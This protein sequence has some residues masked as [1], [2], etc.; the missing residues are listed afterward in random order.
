MTGAK[1]RLKFQ[2]KILPTKF[3]QMAQGPSRPSSGPKGP[4]TGIGNM[5]PAGWPVHGPAHGPQP[6]PYSPPTVQPVIRRGGS[7]M[8]TRAELDREEGE[9]RRLAGRPDR[10]G[11]QPDNTAEREKSRA[12]ARRALFPTPPRLRD[13]VARAVF[14]ILTNYDLYSISEQKRA[15]VANSIS[16]QVEETRKAITK[17]EDRRRS[18]TRTIETTIDWSSEAVGADHAQSIRDTILGEIEKVVKL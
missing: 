10:L 7:R 3:K 16:Q 15:L 4:A 6:A 9:R 1:K 17:T 2:L 8:P 14:K 5:T 13:E 12:D 11:R 18:I